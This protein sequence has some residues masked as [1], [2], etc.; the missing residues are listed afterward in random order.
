MRRTWA[1]LGE[2]AELGEHAYA[3]HA[4]VGSAAAKVGIDRLVVVGS[5]A[6]G[7]AEGAQRGGLA[8]SA[9]AR[10]DT[11]DDAI[12]FLES[13]VQADDVVLVKASR[14]ADLQRVAERLLGAE[15]DA[16]TGVGVGT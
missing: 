13:A 2:M 6:A 9:I 16:V 12:A 1:V 5:A 4:E 7:I 3:A 10:V 8:A 11:I 14:S 15:T